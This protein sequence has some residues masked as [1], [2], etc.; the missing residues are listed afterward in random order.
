MYVYMYVCYTYIMHICMCV[1]GY[2]CSR[3]LST[4]ALK[5]T[6]IPVLIVMF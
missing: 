5:A 4:V 2:I 6:Y 1:P 3:L